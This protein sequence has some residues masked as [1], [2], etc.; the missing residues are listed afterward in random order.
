MAHLSRA[1]YSLM[2]SLLP[3]VATV[4]GIVVLTQLPTAA[5]LVGVA[6]VAGG[7]AVHRDVDEDATALQTPPPKEYGRAIPGKWRERA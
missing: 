5:E 4:I 3:A 6:L 7:V 2:V 1:A